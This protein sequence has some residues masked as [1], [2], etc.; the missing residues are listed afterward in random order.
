MQAALDLEEKAR[1]L[2]QHAEDLEEE[3]ARAELAADREARKFER[4]EQS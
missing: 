4:N 1:A 2:E 3:A